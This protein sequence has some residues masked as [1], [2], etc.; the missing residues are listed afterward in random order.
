MYTRMIF[1]HSKVVLPQWLLNKEKELPKHLYLVH[2]RQYLRKYPDYKLIKIEKGL[3]L[4]ER[5]IPEKKKGG[6]RKK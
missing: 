1:N 4:C 2:V 3:A 5:P 6:K